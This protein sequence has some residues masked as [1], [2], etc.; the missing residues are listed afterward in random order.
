MDELWKTLETLDQNFRRELETIDKELISSIPDSSP[1]R[2]YKASRHLIEIGGKRIR[3]TLLMLS[4]NALNTEGDLNKILPVAIAVELIHTATIIHDDI[5]DR[6]ALRRGAQTVNA[7]W[8]DDVALIA[9]DLIFSR[10]FGLISSLENKRI[11]EAIYDACRKLAEGQVLD[12]MHTG[13]T[14]MTEEVYLEVIE[15]KTASLFEACTRCGAILGGGNKKEVEALAR[16]GFLL[17]V[18]FQMTDDVLD[19]S[20]GELE[21]GKPVGADVGLGKPTFV[22]LHALKVA[23]ERE[24]WILERTINHDNSSVKD[25]KKALEIIKGTNSIEY[26]SKRAKSFISQGKDEIKGLKSSNA[27]DGLLLIADYAINRDF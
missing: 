26:A 25:I 20:S 15:R 6:S 9:G 8:G 4:H 2:L 16:Y 27:K 18:G 24:R 21:L 7:K 5:I 19:I 22:I 10:A 12:A 17:G 3:P 13:D 14:K 1:S 11:S 23:S